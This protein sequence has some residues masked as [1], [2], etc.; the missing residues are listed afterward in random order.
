MTRDELDFLAEQIEESVRA[1]ENA[2][3]MSHLVESQEVD[4]NT[5]R[6][7]LED[8][9]SLVRVQDKELEALR[10]KVAAADDAVVDVRRSAD[11]RYVVKC[12]GMPMEVHGA[13]DGAEFTPLSVFFA[14]ATLAP[15]LH[16]EIV[17]EINNIN[18]PVDPPT[19]QEVG[20]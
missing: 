8:M 19:E 18:K 2:K 3:D 9:E 11:N 5:M 10:E 17:R 14:E 16:D 13:Y 15:E 6:C 12:Y 1:E 7:R 4:L 20:F